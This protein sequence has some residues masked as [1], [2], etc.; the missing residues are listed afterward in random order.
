MYKDGLILFKKVGTYK[1]YKTTTRL[2]VREEPEIN[3]ENILGE[4]E[5]GETVYAYLNNTDAWRRIVYHER[6]VYVHGDY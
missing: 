1:R 3:N 5:K 6:L 2:N 4:L